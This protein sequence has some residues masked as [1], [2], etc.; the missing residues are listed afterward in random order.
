MLQHGRNRGIDFPVG[1]PWPLKPVSG[2]RH[3]DLSRTFRAIRVT[4][5]ALTCY[6]SV[7]VGNEIRGPKEAK[8][9]ER[10]HSSSHSLPINPIAKSPEGRQTNRR[11]RLALAGAAR[12]AGFGSWHSTAWRC[13]A[14]AQS[15]KA[16]G[17]RRHR[18]LSYN[19]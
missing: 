19:D 5:A 7:G 11:L 14:R 10:G 8:E 9:M 17:G 18:Q 1:S 6:C 15:P 2:K 12:S 3:P 16:I 13:A 4:G